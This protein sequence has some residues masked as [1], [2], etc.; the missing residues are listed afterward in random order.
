M[1]HIQYIYIYIY[2][3]IYIHKH[4]HTHI[5]I[6]IYIE[7]ATNHSEESDQ[8]VQDVTEVVDLDGINS[9]KITK[10]IHLHLHTHTYIYIYI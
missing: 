2:T 8:N 1:A 6:Y 10:H 9:R 5:Y 4:T 7:K 3:Y